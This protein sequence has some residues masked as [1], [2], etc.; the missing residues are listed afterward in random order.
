MT[1]LFSE[2]LNG[3]VFG[4]ETAGAVGAEAGVL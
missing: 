4:F 2:L 1:Y 3:N